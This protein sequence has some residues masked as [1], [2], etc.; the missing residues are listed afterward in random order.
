[1]LS[2]IQDA[3]ILKHRT[4]DVS[5]LHHWRMHIPTSYVCPRVFDLM[6]PVRHGLFMSLSQVCARPPPSLFQ[7]CASD[8]AYVTGSVSRGGTVIVP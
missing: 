7:Q 3:A 2:W 6:C 5:H 8:V 1:M 4:S